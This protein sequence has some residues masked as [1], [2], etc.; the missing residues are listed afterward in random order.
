MIWCC[1]F[2]CI[3]FANE[4]TSITEFKEFIKD[5]YKQCFKAIHFFFKKWTDFVPIKD[6]GHI[7]VICNFVLPKT[8][9]KLSV[10]IDHVYYTLETE[11]DISKSIV[12][13]FYFYLLFPSMIYVIVH[14]WYYIIWEVTPFRKK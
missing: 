2:D 4:E 7:I 12:R 11:P 9:A 14:I 13:L 3:F 5:W 6:K 8:L 10:N 1:W